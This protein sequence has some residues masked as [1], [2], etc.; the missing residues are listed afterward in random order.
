VNAMAELEG[1]PIHRTYPLNGFDIM[2][3]C[4]FVMGHE[5]GQARAE[6]QANIVFT[7]KLGKITMLEFSESAAIIECGRV[8]A[9]ENLERILT[10][11]REWQRQ[12][13]TPVNK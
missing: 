13:R 1:Q 7:P 12:P 4:M 10:G 11:Y 6:Q 9:R 5:I 2:T 8:A 3:R